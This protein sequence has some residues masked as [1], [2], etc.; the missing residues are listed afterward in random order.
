MPKLRYV[1]ATAYLP[2]VT[3]LN[4]TKKVKTRTTVSATIPL[5]IN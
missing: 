5:A 3:T 1:L 4:G 2:A